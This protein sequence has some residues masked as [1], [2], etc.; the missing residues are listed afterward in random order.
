MGRASRPAGPNSPALHQRERPKSWRW[1]APV[2]KERV[3]DHCP[4]RHSGRRCHGRLSQQRCADRTAQGHPRMHRGRRVRHTQITLATRRQD[5][6]IDLV[7]AGVTDRRHLYRY[8]GLPPPPLDLVGAP[9]IY[10]IAGLLPRK[11]VEL[12]VGEVSEGTPLDLGAIPAVKPTRR[13][14]WPGAQPSP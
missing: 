13:I 3:R 8:L 12:D 11:L 2:D 10:P 4:S 5:R 6:A 1:P 9:Q 7:A 14:S